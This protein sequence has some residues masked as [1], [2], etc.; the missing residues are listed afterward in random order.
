ELLART[1]AADVR[2]EPVVR[3][4]EP[5]TIAP[6]EKDAAAQPGVNPSQVLGVDSDPA[7]IAL[8]RSGDNTQPQ[9]IHTCSCSGATFSTDPDYARPTDHAAPPRRAETVVELGDAS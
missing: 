9:L 3:D 2:S 6:L 1:Q 8:A 4:A 7:L 5:L